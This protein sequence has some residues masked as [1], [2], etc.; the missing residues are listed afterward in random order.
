VTTPDPD[1][2]ERKT[3]AIG[4]LLDLREHELALGREP[5][6]VLVHPSDYASFLRD[7]GI[8]DA[9]IA[10][11]AEVEFMGLRIVQSRAAVPGAYRLLPRAALEA[12][13]P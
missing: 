5:G 12:F 7:L 6:G 3:R 9:V 10:S 4:H 1:L 11:A 13:L 8:P 2:L